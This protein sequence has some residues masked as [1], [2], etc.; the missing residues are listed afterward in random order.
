MILS[1]VNISAIRSANAKEQ[2]I[3]MQ[4]TFEAVRSASSAAQFYV[5]GLHWKHTGEDKWLTSR[6]QRLH[7]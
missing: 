7:L 4:D 5:R 1:D 6:I 3:H 2:E